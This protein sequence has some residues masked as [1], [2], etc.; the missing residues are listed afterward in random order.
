MIPLWDHTGTPRGLEGLTHLHSSTTSGSACLIKARRRESISPRQSPRSWIF[1]SINDDA[2]STE[3][4]R[5]DGD[6]IL[7]KLIFFMMSARF[8]QSFDPGHCSGLFSILRTNHCSSPDFRLA[9]I[10]LAW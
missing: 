6:S 8:L 4:E 7:S 1:A 2:G 10:M 5:V 3:A 9:G